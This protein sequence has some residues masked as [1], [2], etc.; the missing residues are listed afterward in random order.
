MHSYPENSPEAAARVIALL[1][2]SDGHVSRS[3][4]DALY[5]LDIERELGLDPGAFARVLRTLCEDLLM[6]THERRVLTGSVNAETLSA[7]LN[8]VSNPELQDMV[9]HFASTAVAADHH[10]AAAEA[11]IM[12]AALAQWRLGKAPTTQNAT[13]RA[14]TM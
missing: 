3:E 10:V 2:I 5:G 6:G 11:W 1:L 13:E 12:E 9:L 8:D 4:M 7:L 14:L